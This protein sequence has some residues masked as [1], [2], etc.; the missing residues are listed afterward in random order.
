MYPASSRQ[1]IHD[2]MRDRREVSRQITHLQS[3]ERE[4]ETDLKQIVSRLVHVRWDCIEFSG[5]DC[6][7]SPTKTC[8]YDVCSALGTDA[9]LFCHDPLERK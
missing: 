1:E 4:L 2:I 9:C 5:W 3:K 6:P 7:M 8:I